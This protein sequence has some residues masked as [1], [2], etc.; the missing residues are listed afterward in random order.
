ML[1][2]V[3]SEPDIWQLPEAVIA[4]RLAAVPRLERAAVPGAGHFVHM[5]RPRE[6]ADL[7][8]GALEP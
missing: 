6:L 1:A 4:E 2:V 8:L 7:L 3:G 5:E